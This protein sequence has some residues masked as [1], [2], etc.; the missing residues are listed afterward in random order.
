MND[1]TI[2]SFVYYLN[3]TKNTSSLTKF[4]YQFNKEAE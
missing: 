3:N 1:Y 2:I 4:Q